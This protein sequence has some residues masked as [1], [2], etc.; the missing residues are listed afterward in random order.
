MSTFPC[1]ATTQRG[2][3]IAKG[4]IAAAALGLQRRMR[5]EAEAAEAIVQADH[6]HA[7]AREGRAGID[8]RRT[9]AVDEAAAM[10]PDHHRPLLLRL[11]RPPDVEIEAVLRGLGAQR[12]GV[13]G[14]GQLRAIR[15]EVTRVAPAFPA[16]HGLRIAPAVG[17]DRGRGIGNAQECIHAVPPDALDRAVRDRNDRI[18]RGPGASHGRGR[19]RRGDNRKSHDGSLH[20]VSPA[21]PCAGLRCRGNQNLN[22]RRAP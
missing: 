15:R 11:G 12:R 22:P 1:S 20:A 3:L 14:K 6:H 18:G 21:A 19:Q 4:E 13:S 9:A 17:A 5:E 2:D 16:R 7:V 8:R 10:E